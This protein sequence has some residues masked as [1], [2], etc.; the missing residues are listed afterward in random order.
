MQLAVI[1]PADSAITLSRAAYY[2]R[3]LGALVG[4][5]IGDAMGAPVEMWDRRAMEV[6]W[7][8]I[9]QLKGLIREGMP[10]G[11]WED[12]LPPGGT[13]DDTRWKYF[14]AHFLVQQAQGQPLDPKAFAQSI[15]ATYQAEQQEALQ[16]EAFDPEP[17]ERSLR[18]MTWLQEW[19]KVAQPYIDQDLDGYVGA[20]N[21]FYGGEMACGGM[22]YAPVIGLNYPGQ[23]HTAYANAYQLGIFDLGYARDLTGLSAAM[24]ARA[25]DSSLS[26]EE[27]AAVVYEVDPEAYAN[28]RL[29]GRVAYTY[30]KHAQNI[31]FTAHELAYTSPEGLR[32]P[33]GYLRDTLAFQRQQL[34]YQLLDEHLSEIPFHAGEIYL[35]GMTAML[36]AEGD[37][38]LAMEFIV[39][40]GRDNDTV[41]AIVGAILGAKLGYQQL[42]SVLTQQTLQINR[43]V[44]GIDLEALAKLLTDSKFNQ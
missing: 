41:A 25:M 27:I 12:N 43:E 5:A 19:A 15:V 28:S 32:I 2:D 18:H 11:P 23:A 4:S 40:Y 10:E 44:V 30:Y 1:N 39:N 38:Q 36:F 33:R 17:L 14:M 6:H 3:V 7:G 16:T 21:K 29:V 34:A 9:T 37:F 20:L 31:A 35:I 26:I 22:L 13:T 8:Y 24:V 42:P